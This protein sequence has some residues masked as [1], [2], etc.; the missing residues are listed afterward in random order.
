MPRSGIYVGTGFVFL[1]GLLL[2]L[3][4]Q[5]RLLG[6]DGVDLVVDV[7]DHD[8]RFEVD[9]VVVFRAAA[10]FF[11]LPVLAHHDQRRLNGR[12]AGQHQIQQNKREG[13]KRLGR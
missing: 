3:L 2:Q 7:L 11:L 6:E 10:V 4:F 1:S 13:V 5:L 8:F 12:Y 9:L